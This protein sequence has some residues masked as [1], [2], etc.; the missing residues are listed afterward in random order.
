MISAQARNLKLDPNFR[1]TPLTIDGGVA[2]FR[3]L[4]KDAVER[5]LASHSVLS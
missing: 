2:Q 4:V 5:E 3:R 1:M